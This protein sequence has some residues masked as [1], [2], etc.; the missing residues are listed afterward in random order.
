MIP[1]SKTQKSFKTTKKTLDTSKR[2]LL[3][4]KKNCQNTESILAEK[5]YFE[6]L[7]IRKLL[8]KQLVKQN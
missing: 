6:Y 1:F 4:I 3:H 7:K 5:K 2:A 8:L